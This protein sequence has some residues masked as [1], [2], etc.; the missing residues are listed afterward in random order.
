MDNP[1]HHIVSVLFRCRVVEEPTKINPKVRPCLPLHS[2]LYGKLKSE[3]SILIVDEAHIA[4]NYDSQLNQAIRSLSCHHT[5]LLSGTPIPNQWHAILGQTVLLPG[6]P[7]KDKTHF[8]SVCGMRSY[9]RLETTQRAIQ[10]MDQSDGALKNQLINAV[11]DYQPCHTALQLPAYSYEG[12]CN[13]LRTAVSL[14]SS[15]TGSSQYPADAANAYWTDRKY[16]GNGR[17][18]RVAWL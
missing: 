16:K 5:F 8:E 4:K 6:S 11:R 15:Q 14:Q 12:L 17:N 13:Q 3:I 10:S 2:A 1:R 9:S 18:N 7:F